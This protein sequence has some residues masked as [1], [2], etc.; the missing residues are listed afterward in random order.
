MRLHFSFFFLFLAHT[1][2]ADTRL[3]KDLD[4]LDVRT[5]DYNASHWIEQA[6]LQTGLPMYGERDMLITTLS[7][8]LK[9]VDWIQTAYGSGAYRGDTLATFRLAGDAQVLIACHKAAARPAWLAAYKTTG[10]S[11]TNSAGQTFEFVACTFHAGDTVRLGNSG[12]SVMYLVA[13]KALG[14]APALSR[15]S[16]KVFDVLAYG[17]RGDGKTVN[18]LSLQ[19]AIDA[20]SAAG[21]GSVYIHDGIFVTGTLELKDHVT[22]W[23]EAGSILRGS[24]DH[25]DYIPK[26]CALPSYRGKED[27]QLI[28]AERRRDIG[29]GGG[30]IIDGYSISREWPWKDD[31]KDGVINR[32]RM[33]RMVECRDIRIDHIS[34]IRGCYWTQYYEACDSLSI[35]HE[36]VRCYTG[37]DNQDGIDISGCKKVW[38]SNYYAI[39][40]DDAVCIKTMSASSCEDLDIREVIVRHAN[41]H[42]VKIGTE[43]HSDVRRVRVQQVVA[44]ARYGTAIES[45]DGSVVEDI[46]YDGILL[47][48]CSVP[49]FIRLGNRG[50]VYEGGPNPAPPSAMRNI[51]VRNLVNTGIGYVEMRDGPGVGSVISGI[52]GH[53]IENLTIENCRL[54]YY[55]SRTDT[56]LI[57]RDVP[58][59]EQSYPEFNLLGVLP[60]YGLFTR[61]VKGLTY[62]NLD[63]RCLHPDVRPAIVLEDVS[64]DT[65]SK[66]ECASFPGTQPAVIWRKKKKVADWP[67]GFRVDSVASRVDRAWQ[68]MY[69]FASTAAG[70]QPLIVSLHTWSGNYAQQDSLA[71]E[72]K[73]KNWNYVHPDFRGENNKPQA[74]GSDLAIAD[75]DDAI[76]W[77]IRHF[78]V[79]TTR[80]YVV[81]VSGGGYATLCAYGRLKHEV[82]SFTAWVPISDIGAWY[83]ESLYLTTKYARNVLSVT[84]STPD[85]LNREEVIRRSPLYCPV[86]PGRL[87]HTPLTILAGIHDGHGKNSVP[88]TQSLLYYNKLLRDKR[89]KD[90]SAYVPEKDMLILL[91]QQRFP[92]K[93]PSSIGGRMI[94]YQKQYRNI[95][96]VIFE[97]GHEMLYPV[98]AIRPEDTKAPRE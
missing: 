23:V 53:A 90:P 50:R 68:K 37:Q 11:L 4:V 20:C 84:R 64:G 13:V 57:Y 28:Y 71:D 9:G 98:G 91:T 43:T 79:D 78:R 93:Q 40:G 75:I 74:G 19:S 54:L 97:G 73:A 83:Y 47:T 89:V 52:P 14:A 15:P 24:T 56:S 10:W 7:R 94:Y 36:R 59:Q 92:V 31:K 72:T 86:P 41:C 58:E 44:H 63:L 8:E 1:V 95:R 66:V 25:G 6:G 39:T 12:D 42:A 55:G 60:A 35:R 67:V 46:V 51:M 21:G 18:T 33:I 48:G 29:I 5:G 32:P 87:Q 45:V 34:L 26:R 3:I 16:G 2:L 96:V 80:I 49:V 30:G 81:G 82:A 17:A 77:A 85:S 38:L 70:L 27:F 61:H 62:R 76:D 88:V 65:L 22:L 69:V